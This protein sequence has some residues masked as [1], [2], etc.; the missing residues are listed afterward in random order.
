[1]LESK[2]LSIIDP[3]GGGKC[4]LFSRAAKNR[5]VGVKFSLTGDQY[6]VERPFAQAENMIELQV[7]TRTG[8]TLTIPLIPAYFNARNDEVLLS[9]RDGI[10]GAG[11]I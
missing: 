6:G 1:M 5:M 8:F 2:R 11:C 4:L 10:A 9:K 3:L 7:T